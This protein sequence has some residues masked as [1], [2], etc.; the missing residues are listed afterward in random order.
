M[1]PTRFH[2]DFTRFDTVK[3]SWNPPD[4]IGWC[5]SDRRTREPHPIMI[6]QVKCVHVI[7]VRSRF[8]SATSKLEENCSKQKVSW[9]STPPDLS[10]DLAWE[11]IRFHVCVWFSSAAVLVHNLWEY[12]VVYYEVIHGK[13]AW[14]E[15][16][17]HEVHEFINE[18]AWVWER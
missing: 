15:W 11:F 13:C 16:S 12:C 7:F 4:S 6:R 18:R 10:Q 9:S 5:N 17:V 8:G 2:W 1:K 3:T 14:S